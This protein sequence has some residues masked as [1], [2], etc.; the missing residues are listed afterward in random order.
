MAVGV[1]SQTM[2]Y[3]RF[4]VQISN[5]QKR[6][7]YTSRDV[8]IIVAGLV[9]GCLPCTQAK[10]KYTVLPALLYPVILQNNAVI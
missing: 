3:N 8:R 2:L 9:T 7:Y 10:V 1:V 4:S 6:P 5:A